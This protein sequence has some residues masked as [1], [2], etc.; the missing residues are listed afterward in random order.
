M[1]TSG[2]PTCIQ[3]AREPACG[4]CGLGCEVDKPEVMHA[5]MVDVITQMQH[6]VA[7]CSFAQL[8]GGACSACTIS[9]ALA[10]T[11]PSQSSSHAPAR[12]TLPPLISFARD[13]HVPRRPNGLVP[14]PAEQQLPPRHP[15]H[16]QARTV[17]P[18]QGAEPRP[19]PQRPRHPP[20]PEVAVSSGP[21]ML[22]IPAR[23]SAFHRRAAAVVHGFSACEPG[24]ALWSVA[25]N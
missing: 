11:L 24:G 2:R 9:C 8:E 19:P 10:S 6:T 17:R 18:V 3:Q 16:M 7:P 5:K 22:A 1:R 23:F 13:C 15:H 20:S 25:S 14:P 4:L 12:R 21:C